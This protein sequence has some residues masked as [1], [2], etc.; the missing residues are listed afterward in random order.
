VAIPLQ[1]TTICKGQSVQLHTTQGIYTYQWYPPNGL[2]NAAIYNPVA[3]PTETATYLLTLINGACITNN[4]LTVFVNPIPELNVQPKYSLVLQGESVSLHAI[5]TDSCVWISYNWLSCSACNTTISTPESDIIY[6][7][8]ATNNYGC[9][10]VETATVQVEIEASIYIPNTFTPN[11]DGLNDIFKP[12]CTNI[13][14]LSWVVFDRW[15]LQL[16]QTNEID[17]GWDGTYKGTKCQEDVYVYKL[18]YTDMP[19][20]KNHSLSGHVNI[21]K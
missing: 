20:N 16:F 13:S 2:S 7:V 21:I 1:D 5:S 17:Q 18:Q 12:I 10:T 8:T 15:G 4:T 19:T 14:S 9:S 6:T 3:N 11:G